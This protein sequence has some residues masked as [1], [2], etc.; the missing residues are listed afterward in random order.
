MKNN[1]MPRAV[2]LTRSQLIDL[3]RE[4]EQ[5][6]ARFDVDHQR[7]H[8]ADEALRRMQAG[9]Y[10]VCAICG[11]DIPYARLSVVPETLYCVSC[12]ARA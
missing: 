3:R 7:Y 5:E 12:G 8:I 2:T 9:S 1:T 11:T 10:G 4:L 6:R